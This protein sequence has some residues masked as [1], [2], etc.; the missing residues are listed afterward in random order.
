M[1]EA[2]IGGHPHAR[3]NL[4]LD[5]GKRFRIERANKH[6]IIA[7][8]LG[9]DESMD[10]LKKGYAAGL[11]SEEDFAAVL[12]KHQAAVDATKSPQRDAAAEVD[13]SELSS[14]FLTS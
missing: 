14:P 1:E 13:W 8:N 3:F 6:W 9:H 7:A 2:A 12:R 11:V 5:E 4:G 10:M